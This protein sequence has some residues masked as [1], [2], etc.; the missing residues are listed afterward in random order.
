MNSLPPTWVEVA[1]SSITTNA[2]QR[3]P[4][5]DEPFFY[6]DI[7]SVDRNSKAIVTPQRLVGANAPSRARKQVR[8]GDTL[9]SMTRPNLNAVALVPS[10]LD[11]QI[12]ST[13]F[14]VL[15]P[16]EGID[17]R[18]IAYLVR[19]EAFV[20]AMSEVVQG[21]L[22]PAIRSKDVRSYR[23]PLAPLAEQIRI[24][25]HLD[26]L[27]ARVR[28]CNDRLDAVPALL[29]RFRQAVLDAATSG[30]LTSEWREANGQPFEWKKVRLQDIADLKG[31]L[32]KD[33]KKQSSSDEEVPYLRVANV[34]R[35]YIDLSEIKKI[36][37]PSV[38]LEELLLQ[39]GDI[40][41]NEGGDLDKLG[42][43]WVWEGQIARC[44]F[45]NHVFRARLYDPSNQPKFVS[46]WGNSQGLE[47]FIR[48]GRQTT[49]LASINK[50][51][52]AALPI[53]L[54][55]TDEQAE[56]VRRAEILFKLADRIE[57]RYTAIRVQAQRLSPLLLAKAFRGE[58]VP[59]NSNDE[60][61]SVLLERIK[62]NWESL[63][64]RRKNRR[65]AEDK[66]MKS[67][68]TSS[69]SEIIS[70]MKEDCFTFEQLRE[71]VSCDYESLKGELFTLLADSASG[72]KQVFD[73]E[74]QLMKFKRV[75]K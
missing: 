4:S 27:L 57:A 38:K 19:T 73:A 53:S 55:P 20:K 61:A 41:F 25:D 40:L 50:T 24:A 14:D 51:I 36:R 49:N 39:S 28:A 48:A 12:A 34:Q 68:P 31:G 6:I 10:E 71:L 9:V 54:P 32:T 44:T 11:G 18:W 17:P 43:G 58:L 3:I 16:V 66:S 56:I 30:E 1:F 72:L 13:G 5:S 8:T 69:L 46:W 59:Q 52:L 65:A 33:S 64:A 70:R 42:R 26:K 21:A 23:V 7:G 75:R 60:P 15:R 67:S 63:V 37:V 45:Q 35:G 29:K 22:Y 74:A 2:S 47:Y 62:E